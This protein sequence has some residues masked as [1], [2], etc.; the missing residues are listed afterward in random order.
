ME[1]LDVS[2][3]LRELLTMVFKRKR[4]ILVIFLAVASAAIAYWIV[5]PITYTAKSRIMVKFGREFVAR[6]EVGTETFRLS[7]QSIMATEIELLKGKELLARTLNDIGPRTLYPHLAKSAS[8]ASALKAATAMAAG[9]IEAKNV[10][11]T[12]MIEVSFTHPNREGA[13]MTVNK[14]VEHFVDRHVDVFGG[15]STAFLEQQTKDYEGKLS[16]SEGRLEGFRQQ[17]RVFS[18]EEQRTALITQRGTLESSVMAAQNQVKELQEKLGFLK[19]PRWSVE[20]PGDV[21]TQV[22]TL[23]QRERDLLER[24]NEQSR[25]VQ[26]V[27][28]E[29]ESARRTA[30]NVTEEVRR[31]EISR[32]EGELT[33]LRVRL[34]GLRQQ[35]GQTERELQTLDSKLK[36]FQELRREVTAHES[37]YRTYLQKLEEARISD[38]M[39]RQKMVAIS[40]VEGA[41]AGVTP[42]V[43]KIKTMIIP[44]GLV[45]GLAAGIVVALLLEFASSALVTP[46]AAERR[47]GLPVM[48]AVAKK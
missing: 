38:D 15:K 12:N 35:L 9:K 26:N 2:S 5:L 28:R 24:Y 34:S 48:V 11:G 33:A 13:V 32:V 25:A 7:P 44:L 17:N 22:L 29:L 46:R 31:A 37:S 30:R 10:P 16:T 41:Q 21:R 18:I 40:V 27:R 8:E 36:E 14:L 47:V 4:T 39:D 42:K 3:S 1:E 43:T 20:T 6:S 45:G 19:S 23:E